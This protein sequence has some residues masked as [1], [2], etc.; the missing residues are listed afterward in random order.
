MSLRSSAAVVPIDERRAFIQRTSRDGLTRRQAY[1]RLYIAGATLLL[2]VCILPLL[3]VF[4]LAVQKGMPFIGWR[5]FTA[6]AA[7]PNLVNP[8]AVGGIKTPLQGTLSVV[9]LAL[10]ISVPFAVIIAAS[11]VEFRNRFMSW[12]EVLLSTVIGLPSILFGLFVYAIIFHL[13]LAYSGIMGSVALSMLMVPLIAI[14]SLDALRAVPDTLVEAGVALG[15]NRFSVM[16]HI[17][18][19]KARARIFTG[20][21]LALARA[22]GETAP[23]LFVIGM[24]NVAT[25]SPTSQQTTMTTFVYQLLQSPYPSQRDECWAIALVLIAIVL[26]FNIVG[27]TLLARAERS[28]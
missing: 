3:S 2:A 14:Q 17:I 20:V 24:T 6:N 8:D 1:S 19:P 7:I 5:F 12:L 11:L 9:G 10:V 16:F 26:L 23:V 18:L 27:R 21:F 22:A 15:L 28:K 25:L 13:K 4:S